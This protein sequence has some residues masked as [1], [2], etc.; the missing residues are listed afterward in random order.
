MGGDVWHA[1]CTFQRMRTLHRTKPRAERALWRLALH[2]LFFAFAFQRALT[3]YDALLGGEDPVVV[4]CFAMQAVA[5]LF[6]A[7]C[8]MLDRWVVTSLAVLGTAVTLTG[9]VF[10]RVSGG[11][12]GPVAVAQVFIAVLAT[13]MLATLI[14]TR[15]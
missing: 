2:A 7:A 5:G 12:A 15:D 4:A 11:A 1:Q 8:V 3:A 9:L 13:M 6:S 10:L 14:G